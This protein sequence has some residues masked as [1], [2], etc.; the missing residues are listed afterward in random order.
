MIVVRTIAAEHAQVIRDALLELA[1]SHLV[2]EL[3]LEARE[4]YGGTLSVTFYV[5]ES[6]W[7]AVKKAEGAEALREKVGEAVLNYLVEAAAIQRSSQFPQN[8]LVRPV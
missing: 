1:D 8:R 4:G 5:P 6:K 2:R 3:E 7:D